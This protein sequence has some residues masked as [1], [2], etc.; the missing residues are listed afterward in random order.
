MPLLIVEFSGKRKRATLNGRAS[1]GRIPSNDVVIEHPAVSR[2]HAIVEKIGDSY[3]IIDAHSKNG[4]L[5]GN[6]ELK[7]RQQLKDGDRIAIGPAVLVFRLNDEYVDPSGQSATLS[8]THAG[9]L[10]ACECGAQLWVPKEMIGGRGQCQKCG[11]TLT[12]GESSLVAPNTAVAPVPTSSPSVVITQPSVLPASPAARGFANQPP[13]PAAAPAIAQPC[14]ICQWKIDPGDKPH[15]CPSCG[16]AFHEECWIENRGC[17]AYG[18]DQ[19]NVLAEEE[20]PEPAEEIGHPPTLE[21]SQHAFPW[22]FALLSA[23]VLGSLLGLLA[24]GTTALIAMLFSGWY[25][26]K[27]GRRTRVPILLAA[28]A[29]SLIGL[30]AGVIVSCLWWL[31]MG[32]GHRR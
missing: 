32:M 9:I 10:M 11:R 6:H 3:F 29:V 8:E 27:H 31:N 2:N 7:D 30:V 5:V 24:F 20:A 13:S 22:E 19:V 12:L 17:S 15:I 23:S 4:T 26:L 1:I 14:S 21:P 28:M 18:C 25:L 16:L